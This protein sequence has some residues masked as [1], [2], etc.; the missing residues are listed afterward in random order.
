MY[1]KDSELNLIKDMEFCKKNN[2]YLAAKLVRGA[3][4]NSEHKEGHLYTNKKDTD[5]SYNNAI[6]ELSNYNHKCKIMLATHNEDSIKL[7]VLL[8][9]KFDNNRFSF[10]HLKDMKESYYDKIINENVIDYKIPKVYVYLPYGPYTKM[11]PYLSRRLYEN[12]DML[13]NL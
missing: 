1:R 7:G 9:K 3:Y 10:A 12:L 11:I 2:V 8:N 6:L 5:Y 13:S 4:W